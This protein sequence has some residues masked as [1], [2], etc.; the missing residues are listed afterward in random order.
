MLQADSKLNVTRLR[1]AA[2]TVLAAFAIVSV[3]LVAGVAATAA[4]L[5]ESSL[6]LTAAGIIDVICVMTLIVVFM[7]SCSCW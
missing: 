3:A 5:L 4:L 2:A 1:F 7:L 6:S